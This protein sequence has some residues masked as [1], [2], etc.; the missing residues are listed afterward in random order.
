MF[1]MERQVHKH[2]SSVSSRVASMVDVA[3]DTTRTQ[4]RGQREGEGGRKKGGEK[5]K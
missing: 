2:H 1:S 3:G 4:A 5:R